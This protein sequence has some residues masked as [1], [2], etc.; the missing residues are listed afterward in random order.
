MNDECY[1]V[2]KG[3]WTIPSSFL[4]HKLFTIFAANAES[5]LSQNKKYWK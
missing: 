1:I 4:Y 2:I 5:D 3:G